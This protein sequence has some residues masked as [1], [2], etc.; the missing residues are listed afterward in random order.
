MKLYAEYLMEREKAYLL[1]YEWGFA[2]YK[3]EGDFVYLQDIYIV[4]EL[5]QSGRGVQLMREVAAIGRERGF[6]RLVGSVDKKDS[7]KERMFKIME[8]LNF[9][10]IDED[11]DLIYFIKEI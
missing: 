2:T 8:K 1:D 11:E 6:E 7:N 10:K 9:K 5:R 3:F 4:P